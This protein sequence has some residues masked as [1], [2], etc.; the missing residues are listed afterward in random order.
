MY[1]LARKITSSPASPH[2]SLALVIEYENA[3]N[4]NSDVKGIIT[5]IKEPLI[6]GLWWMFKKNKNYKQN[7]NLL[8]PRNVN[9]V[10][11][12]EMQIK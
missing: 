5:I 2:S 3:H 1:F 7:K 11:G 12:R 6:P 4:F 10:K 8:W 9:W